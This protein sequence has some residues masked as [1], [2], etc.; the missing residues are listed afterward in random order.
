MALLHALGVEPDGGDGAGSDQPQSTSSLNPNLLDRE[1]A[2][3]HQD[4]LRNRT[5]TR[6][7]KEG[8]G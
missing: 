5:T 6:V 8:E 4:Q 1:L 3:L 7:Q 2:A